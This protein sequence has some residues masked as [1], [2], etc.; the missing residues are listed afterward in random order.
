MRC[1]GTTSTSPVNDVA[2]VLGAQPGTLDA[3]QAV[4]GRAEP[5]R[6]GPRTLEGEWAFT[7]KSH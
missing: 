3:E 2:V 1:L 5:V 4:R 6:H 7:R